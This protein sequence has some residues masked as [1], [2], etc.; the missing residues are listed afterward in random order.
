MDYPPRKS[1]I[2]LPIKRLSAKKQLQ[3]N[4]CQSQTGTY[5]RNISTSELADRSESLLFQ[6]STINSRVA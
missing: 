2:K 6:D 4:R 1:P 5:P 3:L